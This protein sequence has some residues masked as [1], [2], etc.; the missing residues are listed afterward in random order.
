MK[1]VLKYPGAK[2]RI[3]S[4][5]VQYF[6]ETPHY[7][8]PYFGSGGAFFEKKP[9]S[10]EVINDCD[11][12]VVNLF[13]VIRTRGH[14]LAS[15][16][17]TTPYARS[18]YDASYT[19][20]D[21]PLENARR[22]LVRCW[23]AHGFVPSRRTG[24]RHNGSKSLQPVTRLWNDVPDRIRA[25]MARLKHAEIEC[26]PALALIERYATAD[27]LIYADPPYVLDTRK[28]KAIYR[29][30]MDDRD[31]HHLLDAL[32]AHPGPVVVSGYA[33]AIYDSCLTHW[34]RVTKRVSAEKGQ[35]RTE[36]L[37]M[38]PVCVARLEGVQCLMDFS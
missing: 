21:D 9:S 5:I 13:T 29:Y 35:I 34:Y 1:P 2:N 7:L 11:D 8:E 26:F 15:A 27:T 32:D 10:H 38:N 20:T 30:E 28:G 31:H 25:S 23:M 12:R 36:V 33:N 16:I 19:L 22:F 6:P 3:A 17:E 14:D 24:W 37:W 18:E 4:W